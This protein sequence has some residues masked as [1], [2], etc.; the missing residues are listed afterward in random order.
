MV[1]SPS[2]ASFLLSG[3]RCPSS[4]GRPTDRV[5]QLYLCWS[6]GPAGHVEASASTGLRCAHLVQS[7]RVPV[8]EA[9]TCHASTTLLR[10]FGPPQALESKGYS[11]WVKRGLMFFWRKVGKSSANMGDWL[12]RLVNMR[13]CLRTLA[14]GLSDPM[15]RSLNRDTLRKALAR[16]ACV[17]AMAR[18]TAATGSLYLA[19]TCTVISH[20]F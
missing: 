20:W 15:S 11:I 4:L 10:S 18:T 13:E 8:S 7:A 19:T 6:H 2:S 9:T 1:R 3:A 5:E 12:R 17:L 16:C 14:N